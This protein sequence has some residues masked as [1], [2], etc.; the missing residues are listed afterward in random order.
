MRLCNLAWYKLLMIHFNMQMYDSDIIV[1]VTGGPGSGKGTQCTRI[2][3][4]FRFT[5]LSVGDLLRNEISS[6]SENG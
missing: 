1:L 6:I 2:V 5:H 4:A 3:Q